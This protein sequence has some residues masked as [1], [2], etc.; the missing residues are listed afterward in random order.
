MK[1]PPKK[2]CLG[3]IALLL[4]A[5][6]AHA[7]PLGLPAGVEQLGPLTP[8]PACPQ[9]GFD[10]QTAKFQDYVI[11]TIRTDG[12][13]CLEVRKAD[14]VVLQQSDAVAYGIGNSIYG[15]GQEGIPDIPI[16]TDVTGGRIPEVI[17]WS[18][19]GGAHCCFKFHVLQLGK[20]L[21]P[22]AEIDAE[23]SDGAHFADVNHDGKYEFIGADWA[24][25]YWH[26]SFAQSPAPSIILRPHG[27]RTHK[28]TPEDVSDSYTYHLAFDLMERPAPTT[29]EFESLVQEL[30]GKIDWRQGRVP[31][32]LWG[33]M[34]DFIY[35]GHP[36]LAWKLL[37]QSWPTGKL[38]KGG[39]TGAFC[40]Q[41]RQS[42]YWGDLEEVVQDSHAPAD[43]LW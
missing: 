21:L 34:L 29:A 4:L 27:S 3:F 2:S 38:G 26:A 15:E 32:E 7:S 39:F 23:E 13:G 40:D 6:F 12:L 20:Q 42:H 5:P 18:W 36:P 19:S 31:P 14:T 24:F 17:V 16:G 1:S 43:C 37:D 28:L 25:A 10:Q 35:T 9:D 11:R 41:L 33:A 8:P 22:V 30:K